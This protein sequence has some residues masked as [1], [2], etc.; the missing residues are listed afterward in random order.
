MSTITR[1]TGQ[2]DAE[3]I[4]WLDTLLDHAPA[5]RLTP[6]K[7]LAEEQ[8]DL[9]ARVSRLL[10][11][12]DRTDHP[13]TGG[14]FNQL[15]NETGL[16]T[17]ATLGAYRIVERIGSGGMAEVWRAE[18]RDG[19]PMPPLAIKLPLFSLN[20]PA[21]QQRFLRERDVLATLTHPGIARLIDAGVTDSGQPYLALEYVDGFA[22][23]VACRERG[24]GLEA[25]LRLFIQVLDAVDHA[26]QRLV[27]HRDLKP[28]N[29]LID[30]VGRVRLLDFGVAKLLD[31]SAPG[32]GDIALTQAHG[33]ALT[34][35]YAAPEQL[36]D[37]P[38]STATDVYSLGVM[39]FELLCE[40]SPYGANHAPAARCLKAVIDTDPPKP[41][42]AQPA[43]QTDLTRPGQA[44]RA[45][46]RG[47]LDNIVL[48]AMRKLPQERYV[49]IERFRDDLQR[50]LAHRPVA[51]RPPSLSHRTRLFMRR[52]AGASAVAAVGVVVAIALGV[53]A[54]KQ[55]QERELARARS[56]AVRDF[57]FDL[58]NDAE[59]D[60]ASSS[61]E[62][63]GREM[64]AAAVRRAY[65]Q[66]G[67][68]PRL[69]G[70]LLAELGRMQGRLG[71]DE[72]SRS[73]LS[74]AVLQ[75][76]TTAPADDGALNKAK[77]YLAAAHMD[78]GDMA[79]AAD[80]A[81]SVLD[82]CAEGM[83][84][85]KAR[86][87]ASSVMSRHEL[88][89]GRPEA[90][91]THSERA[92]A[93]SQLAFGP[94][95]A[96]TALA[97]MGL[98]VV[99]RQAG[100]PTAAMTTLDQAIEISRGQTLKLSDRLAMQR[101]RA[102]LSTDLGAYDDAATRIQ[103]TL[104]QAKTDSDR[105]LLQRVLATVQLARGMP[106]M[107]LDQ[108][109]AALLSAPPGV[110]SLLA[111]QARA[112]ALSMQGR[113]EEAERDIGEVITGLSRQGY[114]E[115]SMEV[116]RAR[117]YQAEM[118]LRQGSLTHGLASLEALA[119]DQRAVQSGQETEFAQTL[120]LLGATTRFVGKPEDA[121]SLH[122]QAA[123]LLQARLPEG[124]PLRERNRLLQLLAENSASPSPE[125]GAAWR[126]Q[127]AKYLA[128][129]PATSHWRAVSVRATAQGDSTDTETD[130]LL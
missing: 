108:A 95:D 10:A 130:W 16:S 33:C 87:Y 54:L 46:L 113:G 102:V 19:V 14:G 118:Q 9:H 29:V 4:D 27:V 71:D 36:G 5:E 110:E 22:I 60:E 75:L 101:N 123:R 79:A 103:D 11:L 3:A 97:L 117:R 50:Y 121:R 66:F 112:R 90:A 122:A 126:T 78:A 74:Q 61:L 65:A 70:E 69:Q 114:A 51:A 13:W 129:F 1:G 81:A 32:I 23:D 62:P 124:H 7:R 31:D 53:L 76:T 128:L 45:S 59:R 63:T 28:S 38:I 56:D 116:L 105:R 82:A 99:T 20:S 58:V 80:L 100:R 111:R 42:C 26:H 96:E 94:R 91:L 18:R 25:R 119:K 88:R 89:R 98:A 6:L 93:Q 30:A 72:A 68:M 49:S 109:E 34:P 55:T 12:A 85:A 106:A 77:A 2:G 40:V 43:D 127:H 47:D 84:C 120:D 8:P 57:M 52:H 73:L 92:V 67:A 48:K 24:L 39:L 104:P 125:A 83:D 37:G 15:L 41:S 21:D 17:G 64:V 107:A 115:R 35:R 86:Y 44:W